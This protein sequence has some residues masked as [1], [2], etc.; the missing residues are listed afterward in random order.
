MAVTDVERLAGQLIVVGFD[1]TSA[2]DELTRE[3]S[4][5]ALGGVI[6]FKRNVTDDLAQV[7]ELNARLA[8]SAPA[9][10]PMLISVDQE[11]GRV[12]RLRTGV[13]QLPPMMELGHLSVESLVEIGEVVSEELLALGFTMSFA[14]V[15]DVH[16][17]EDNPSIGDRA[18]G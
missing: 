4:D 8:S 18:F 12:R 11:G 16:S 2:P 13:M 14:P 1:G 6:L 7:A 17:N 15:L 10:A 5:G 3:I 9:N